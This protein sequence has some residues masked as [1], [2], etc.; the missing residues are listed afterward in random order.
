M[1]Y[2]VKNVYRILLFD[3][4]YTLKD[5]EFCKVSFSGCALFVKELLQPFLLPKNKMKFQMQRNDCDL[6]V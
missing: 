1:K 3:H 2:N 4:R 6:Y 5:M